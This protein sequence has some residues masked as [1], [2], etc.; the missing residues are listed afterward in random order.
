MPIDPKTGTN[1][2]PKN[3]E[4]D[5]EN[6]ASDALVNRVLEA[7]TPKLANVVNSAVTAHAKRQQTATEKQ[8]ADAVAKA[9]E[10]LSKNGGGENGAQGGQGQGQNAQ[11]QDAGATRDPKL[12]QLQEK[13]EQLDKQYREERAARETA[14]K[15]AQRDAAINGL[16]DQLSTF[17]MSPARMRA[18]IADM[19][20]SG[21]FRQNPDT[22]TYELTVKRARSRGSRTAEELVYTDF[23]EGLRDWS[24]TED[25]AEFLPAQ[26]QQS[27]QRGP[28]QGARGSAQNGAVKGAAAG[29]KQ[30]A[31]LIDTLS[32]RDLFGGD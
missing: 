16:R 5:D 28:A 11:G 9:L 21:Q 32:E 25:A 8:I 22:G 24:Q 29:S 2:D 17:G 4:H 6:D 1:A 13:F 15:K 23:A 20:A 12:V 19:E 3:S 26:Q 7:L 10:P 18:V 31:N 30:P 27:A 14:E